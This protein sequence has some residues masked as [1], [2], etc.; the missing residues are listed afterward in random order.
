MKYPLIGDLLPPLMLTL[1]LSA[2][3]AGLTSEARSEPA[4]N[5]CL[6]AVADSES[7]E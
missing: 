3:I 5:G 2:F 7:C 6:P 1:L 4:A